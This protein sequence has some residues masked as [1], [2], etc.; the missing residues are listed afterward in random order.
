MTSGDTAQVH[1][2]YYM[3]SQ[4]TFNESVRCLTVREMEKV[5]MAS[6]QSQSSMTQATR[7]Q[8]VYSQD[9]FI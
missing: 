6:N 7:R 5:T 3:F 8:G 1:L 2:V 9:H 4:W